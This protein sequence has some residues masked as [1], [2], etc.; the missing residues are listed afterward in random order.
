MSSDLF[1][2]LKQARSDAVG[3]LA[4]KMRPQSLDAVIGQAHLLGKDGLLRRLV[5][6]KRLESM[7]FWGPPGTGKTTVARLLVQ[8]SSAVLEEV[9]AVFSGVAALKKIFEQARLRRQQGGKTVV[10][11]DEIHRF[12]KA[13]Q[14][15]LLP[16]IEDGTITLIGA[17][18]ENP[19]FELNSALLSR[20]RVVIFHRH[21]KESLIKLLHRAEETEKRPLPLQPEAWEALVDLVDGDARMLLVLADWLWAMAREGEVFSAQDLPHLLERRMPLYDKGRDGRHSLISALHKSVRGS[22]PDAA[23]YYFARMVDAGEEILYLARRLVRMASEDIGLADP[24]ALVITNAAKEA[25]ILLG[26]PEGELALAQACVYLATAP[27]SNSLYVAFAAAQKDA[28]EKGTFS[29]PKHILNAPTKLMKSQGYGK[30]Y[31]YDHDEEHGFSGQEYFPEALGHRSY[32]VP[33]ERGF[34]REIK[35]RL[36][37]WSKLKKE[38]QGL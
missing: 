10:F 5:Q 28:K 23:L 12:N 29:P 2:D 31:R 34:E 11:I 38:K 7:V 27:K 14:D 16:V 33:V 22:D 18:T 15:S 9:S 19:S 17:T 35:K 6:Q 8:D 26:S 24:Q 1:A 32:Y 30:G 4:Q 21:D 3:N 25:Y 13:Q 37:W 20:V 36:L